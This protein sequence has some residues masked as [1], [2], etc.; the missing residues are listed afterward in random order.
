LEN[1]NIT[2]SFNPKQQTKFNE[3][4]S[5]KSN[6]YSYIDKSGYVDAS[7]KRMGLILARIGMI[8]SIIELNDIR[9]VDTIICSD[10]VFECLILILE[11]L[12]DHTINSMMQLP[13]GVT[14]NLKSQL[15][16]PEIL[17]NSL[18]D[19]FDRKQAVEVGFKLKIKSDY[20]DKILRNLSLFCRTGRGRYCKVKPSADSAVL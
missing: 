8:L 6:D 2:F 3:T 11:N 7:I 12:L 17:Y 14:K 13:K 15:K 16:Q 1:Q 18:P 4:L 19:S 10:K 5:K 9:N 20:L